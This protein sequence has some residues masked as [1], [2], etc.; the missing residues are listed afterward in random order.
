MVQAC[1]T[2]SPLCLQ[3]YRI[4]LAFNPRTP[5]AN[6]RGAIRANHLQMRF[7]PPTASDRLNNPNAPETVGPCKYGARNA[8]LVRA[9]QNL[10]PGALV[11]KL[12]KILE[13]QDSILLQTIYSIE[14]EPDVMLRFVRRQERNKFSSVSHR[15]ESRKNFCKESRP[16][17]I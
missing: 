17:A 1:N 12:N 4:H 10:E 8:D 7:L 6:L 15:R 3:T 5:S 11:A 13:E 16:L 2:K 14:D 9:Q